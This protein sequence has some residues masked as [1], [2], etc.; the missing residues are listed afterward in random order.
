VPHSMRIAAL[1]VALAAAVSVSPAASAQPGSAPAVSPAPAATTAP[2]A[3]PTPAATDTTRLTFRPYTIKAFDGTDH[4]VE[5]GRLVVPELH[6]HPTGKKIAIIFLRFKSPSPTPGPPIV[7]LPGGPGY[8]GTLLARTPMYI[9]LFEKLSAR[10]DVI[11]IDQRGSG[12]S[13]PTLQCAVRG[14]LPLDAFETDVK[15]AGAIG[16]MVRPCVH[17]VRND[18]IAIEAYNTVE[19]AEDLEDLRLALGADKLSLI[20]ASYGTELALET[21]RRNGDRIDAAVLVGTRGPDMA[22]RLPTA[23][24]FQLKRFAGFVATDPKWGQDLPDFEGTVRHLLERLAW[25]PVS[26][27]I[28]D[29]KTGQRVRVRVGQAGVQAILGSDLNDWARA[30]L[31]PAIFGS[32]ARGDS[33][34]FFRRVEDL[35]NST[36]SGISVMQVATDCASGASIERKSLVAREAGKALLGNVKNMLVNPAF[37]D[38]VGNLDLGAAFREPI[39]SPVR[40]LF[41]TGD[42]DG[43]TPPFQAEEVRWGFPNGTHIVVENGWH[44]LLPFHDPQQVVVDFFAGQDVRGRRVALPRPGF[45]TIA[46]AK[47]YTAPRSERPAPGPEGPPAR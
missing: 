33:T 10:S 30:P 8:P 2:A 23:G 1:V 20:G 43:V 21:I 32:L 4:P 47:A 6:A 31:L 12:L 36:A 41:L 25:R 17:M 29:A 13:E 46:A 27:P 28:T 9:A 42:L 15:I 39:Y 14:S 44:E 22:W 5:M 11:V 37:C 24:D 16:S 7:F 19:S 26:V 18:G 38:L 40:T 3:T 45:L 34:L 35:V